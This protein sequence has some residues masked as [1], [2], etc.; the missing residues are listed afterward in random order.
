MCV[1]IFFQSPKYIETMNEQMSLLVF[2][3]FLLILFKKE[4]N[5]YHKAMQ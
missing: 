1:Q 5:K 4:I 2:I 3:F